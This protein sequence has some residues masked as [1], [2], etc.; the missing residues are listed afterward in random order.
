LPIEDGDDAPHV[1]RIKHHVV[2]F[3]I[4]MHER[5]PSRLKRQTRI[6]PSGECIHLWQITCLRAVPTISPPAYLSRD[7]TGRLAERGESVRAGVNRMQT[8]E[9]GHHRHARTAALCRLLKQLRRLAVAHD[10]T[11]PPLH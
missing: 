10:E 7:E 5:R 2:E 11:A 9:R 8:C 1:A 4:A 6:E 3:E